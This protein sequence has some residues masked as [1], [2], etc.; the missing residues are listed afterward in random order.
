MRLHP[1][2]SHKEAGNVL[3]L[4]LVTAA[5]LG[6]TLTSFLLMIRHQHLTVARSQAWNNAISAAEAGVEDALQFINK[7]NTTPARLADWS[8][9]TSLA[10][11][12]WFES[13]ANAYY[14]VR[15][16]GTNYRT[17]YVVWIT[18]NASAP[19]ITSHG[20]VRYDFAYGAPNTVAAVGAA[21][22]GYH[23]RYIQ[24]T[25]HVKTTRD[26]LYRAAM[27]ADKAID[28]NGNNIT[29]DSFDSADPAHSNNGQYDPSKRKDNGDVVTNFD[30]VNALSIG[31]ANIM[32]QVKTGPGGSISIGAN[33]SAGSEAWVAGGNSG[34]E[35]GYADDDMNVVWHDVQ[36]PT[37]TW[38]PLGV[39]NHPLNGD[40]KNVYKYAILTS[41]DYTISSLADKLYIAPEA[42]DVRLYITGNV[43]LSGKDEIL[44]GDGAK[45]KVY[46]AG[47]SFSVGGNG[48]INMNSRAESF[49]YFGLPSNTSVAFG[50]N[51]AFIGTI[52]APNADFTLGGGGS[53]ALDFVGASITKSVR[54]NGHYHFHYDENLMNVGAS[55]GYIPTSWEEM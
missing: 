55:R 29:T 50:G 49:S 18:N 38:T 23:T 3:V 25:I 6:A 14:T 15:W 28:L 33:G 35:P 42:K 5:I 52:Y 53:D 51:A 26:S 43:S 37:T 32:G 20:Y 45:V 7:Y 12:S 11:D 24:R 39:V 41:G 27:A 19:T 40:T 54:M 1:H 8:S 2:S 9:S 44:I 22:S 34:I 16:I 21:S 4:S 30:V 46:M 31:N 10:E 13:G 36:V 17:A 48:V 47:A